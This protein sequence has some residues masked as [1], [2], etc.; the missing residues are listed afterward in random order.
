MGSTINLNIFKKD[1]TFTTARQS[2]DLHYNLNENNSLGIGIQSEQS[3]V[4]N[5][6]INTLVEDYK[7]EFYEIHYK[8][9][10]RQ[11]LDK[12]NPIKTKL[13]ISLAFGSRKSNNTIKQRKISLKGSKIFNLN[14][15][16]FLGILMNRI[17]TH[18]V[19]GKQDF[20]L[21]MPE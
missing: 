16:S 7:S 9:K 13:D 11:K 17:I 12:L 3:N 21:L 10:K 18:G 8:Y 5:N 20:Q 2:I 14:S 15:I 6:T 1:S 19:M 4:I